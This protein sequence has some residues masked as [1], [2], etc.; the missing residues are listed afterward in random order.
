MQR[1]RLAAETSPYLLQHADNP[2]DWYPWGEPALLAAKRENKP[3]L[4]SIGYSACHWCH[5][6]AHESFEDPATAALMNE[7][8]INIKVDR[9]ERPDLDKIYQV[10]QQLITHGSGGW[11]LT[12]FLAPEEQTPFFGGTYF[13]KQPRYGM[14]AFA[15]LLRRVADYYRGHGAEIVKQNEQLKLAFAGLMPEPAPDDVVLDPSPLQEGRAALERSFDAEFGGFSQAPKFPHPTSIERCLRHWHA[16]SSGAKPDLH[17][18]YM[19][20]LTLTRMAEGGLYDQLGGGFSRYSVDG[21]WMIPHFEKM[22]YDNAQLLC[23][24]ARAALA[25]GEAL[26][27]RIAG[28]TADWMLRDMRSPSGAFYSSLDADSEGHEGKF[29]VWTPSEV[30][31]LLIPQDYAAFSRRFGLDRSANF[32]GQWHL[33]GYESID[34]VAAALGESAEAVSTRIDSARAELLKVRDL[35]VWPARDEKI[36]TAWNALAIKGLAIAARVLRRPDLAAAASAAVDFIRHTLWRDG[37]LLATYK[38][39]R[40]H[41][42]AYLD[43]YAFLADALLE[44]LQTRWRSSDLDFARQLTDVLLAQFED[45]EAGG[46]FFTAADHEKLI[47]RSK[48]YSDDS[49][50]SGNGVAVSVLCRLGYLLGEIPYLDAAQRTL[51]AAWPMLR[52]YPQ[53]HMSLVNAL[54]EFLVSTQILIIRGDAAHVERWSANLSA[55]Y[56]PTRMIFAIPRD[57][58]ELPPALAAKRAAAGTVAYLCTG[59]T[60]SEPLADLGALAREL[61][62]RIA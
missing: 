18:L 38:D 21:L 23:E 6:M 1:N 15:D 4:L 9:E 46:F 28:E 30:Q 50:P 35:R 39:G 5:V 41:L 55:L 51:K 45:A 16:A 34:A 56:A 24:Y 58:A 47:Y 14:P 52:Q 54:E 42:P 2:V 11:P 17:A 3:I 25:T 7:L 57:A 22:L 19:A 8:F 37:R 26:F 61:K 49:M 33:H 10:A 62:L 36:L 59:M 27:A 44:L 60:C 12:M 32:E 31:A 29:Y 48:T 53:G 40:A 43:D 20:T 13:P